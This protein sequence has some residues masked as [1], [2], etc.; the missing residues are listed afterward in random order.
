MFT[1]IIEGLGEVKEI[2]TI[3]SNKTFWV[4]SSLAP[5]LK[6]DQSLAHN[7]VCLTVEDLRDTIYR[8]TAVA[9]TLAK[10]TLEAWSIGSVINLERSLLPSSRLDGHF[11]QGH[12]DT[13]GTC[14]KI[15]HKNGSWEM[16]FS[17]PKN[18][19]P[20]VIEKGSICLDG[21]SLTVFGAKK[22]S[23]S[24]A[25]IPYTF[26]H[27]NLKNLKAGDVVNLEF[28]LIG[29]YLLRKSTFKKL[30]VS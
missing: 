10:T 17:F 30:A 8:V 29:K 21:I 16:R 23:F 6:V 1:G 12:V 18:F 4:E 14:E 22:K 19:A 5:E 13:T 2:V 20:L 24:V 28:D 9:E 15:E 11:V 25:I 26:E 7:G 27:T 3:G